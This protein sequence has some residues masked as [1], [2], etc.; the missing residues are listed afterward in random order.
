[1]KRENYIVT[2]NDLNDM[3][4][5]A[6][7]GTGKWN[8]GEDG[9]RGA[10]K[11]IMLTAYEASDRGDVAGYPPNRLVKYQ[12]ALGVGTGCFQVYDYLAAYVSGECSQQNDE[13]RATTIFLTDGAGNFLNEVSRDLPSFDVEL[14][15]QTIDGYGFYTTLTINPA[16]LGD[17]NSWYDTYPWRIFY[18]SRIYRADPYDG[19]CLGYDQEYI[20][21]I[22]PAMNYCTGGS[23]LTTF[24]IANT[25]NPIFQESWA[26]DLQ[27]GLVPTSVTPNPVNNVYLRYF[28]PRVNGQKWHIQLPAGFIIKDWVLRNFF[29]QVIANGSEALNG[30]LD[31]CYYLQEQ[32]IQYISYKIFIAGTNIQVRS[33]NNV[34][35]AAQSFAWACGIDTFSTFNSFWL[36]FTNTMPGTVTVPYY[37]QSVWSGSPD[38]NVVVPVWSGGIEL[39]PYETISQVAVCANF[40]STGSS[41][42]MY[43]APMG[44]TATVVGNPNG[45]YAALSVVATTRE[46]ATLDS[47]GWIYL[48]ASPHGAN[49][50]RRITAAGQRIWESVAKSADARVIIGSYF[51]SPGVYSLL[52]STD[53]GVTWSQ[54]AIGGS[55]GGKLAM[56]SSGKY[57]YLLDVQNYPTEMGVWVSSDYGVSFTRTLY[58]NAQYCSETGFLVDVRC[59]NNGK[60]V[61]FIT[62]GSVFRSQDWGATWA[63][64]VAMG[65][66]SVNFTSLT[67]SGDGR[68]QMASKGD[69]SSPA[70]VYNLWRSTNYGYSW[71]FFSFGFK[72]FYSISSSEDGKYVIASEWVSSG[73]AVK[74]WISSSY[75][76]NWSEYQSLPANY[77]SRYVVMMSPTGQYCVVLPYEGSANYSG[78]TYA[79]YYDYTFRRSPLTI[80][81]TNNTTFRT[82]RAQYASAGYR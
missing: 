76:K 59:S 10:T 48:S 23:G 14:Y 61:T 40:S 56:S 38:G 51:V 37:G 53:Y 67:V 3:L 77:A 35:L 72:P 24:P 30:E 46:G 74:I 34:S 21:S 9:P 70:S 19:R 4:L 42:P 15:T 25:N 13:L 63:N 20:V 78:S 50:F 29:G 73:V 44:V 6:G 27:G 80:M 65:I 11:N 8:W 32:Q 22:D 31:L 71:D 55:G 28:Q 1:M 12:D 58:F 66:T 75:G 43:Y 18:Y 68:Y 69:A 54:L 17:S 16:T 5:Q 57:V 26:T 64:P 36:N 60:H 45:P 2:R 33:Y 62:Q 81:Q 82:T 47:G 7:G 41:V 39:G 49:G 79:A 52:R